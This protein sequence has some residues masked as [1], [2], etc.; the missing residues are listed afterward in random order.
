MKMNVANYIL[1]LLQQ[2]GSG[3]NMMVTIGMFALILLVFYFLIIRPQ[4]KKEKE[5]EKMRSNL[6]KND[7][8]LT[9]GGIRGTV[10]QVKE[11]SIIIKVDDNT[12]IEFVK[13]AI[14]SIIEAKEAVKEESK[15]EEKV[16]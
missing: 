7:K 8:V 10:Y 3:I 9:I 15:K 11:D 1:P 14:A 13:N 16:E 12:K 6:K 2:D 5:T 4:R